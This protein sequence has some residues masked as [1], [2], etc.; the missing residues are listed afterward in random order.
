MLT[1]LA[2]RTAKS[3]FRPNIFPQSSAP[4]CTVTF[5]SIFLL[6]EFGL[7][8]AGVR[9]RPSP[10]SL[11]L[12]QCQGLAAAEYGL[13]PE[14][15]PNTP[16]SPVSIEP[17]GTLKSRFPWKIFP[18]SSAPNCKVTFWAKYLPTEFRE[19]PNSAMQPRYCPVFVAGCGNMV[20]AAT[21]S[22]GFRGWNGRWLCPG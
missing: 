15:A 6:A 10:F 17:L 11:A 8:G 2:W 5:S 19:I 9:A 18:Q 14:P 21:I 3:R 12:R 22:G 13:S 7:Y 4:N 20:Q 1:G 16:L